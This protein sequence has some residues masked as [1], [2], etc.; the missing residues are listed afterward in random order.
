[1][2]TT[3][4]YENLWVCSVHWCINRG[5]CS[6]SIGNLPGIFKSRIKRIN[7]SYKLIEFLSGGGSGA[8]TVVN[9]ATVEVRFG[10]AVLIEKLVFN[11]AY[12]KI[13]VAG[14]HFGAHGDTIDLFIITASERKTV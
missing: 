9:A 2:N 1:M 11:V 5:K 6:R 7:N 3:N 8:D 4:N 14:P 10:A 13:E 12:E